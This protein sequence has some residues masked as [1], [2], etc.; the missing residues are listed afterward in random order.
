MKPGYAGRGCGSCGASAVGP[1]A[2]CTHSLGPTP[3][4]PA[5]VP[6]KG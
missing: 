5:P 1:G 2:A 4:C 3:T 6:P